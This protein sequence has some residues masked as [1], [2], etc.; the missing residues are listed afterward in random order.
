MSFLQVMRDVL[1]IEG[2]SLIDY[3]ALEG[4][5]LGDRARRFLNGQGVQYQRRHDALAIYESLT[6]EQKEMLD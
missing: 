6:P 4:S 1:H 3:V 5:V 2:D